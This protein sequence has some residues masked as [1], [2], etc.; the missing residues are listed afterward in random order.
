ML[1]PS[2]IRSEYAAYGGSQTLP[3]VRFPYELRSAGLG[4]RVEPRPP[5]VTR[6]SPLRRDAALG[7]EALKGRIERAVLDQQFIGR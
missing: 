2:R 6:R 1:R 4:E 7:F 5:V 3:A